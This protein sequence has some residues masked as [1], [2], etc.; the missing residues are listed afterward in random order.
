ML[1]LTVQLGTQVYHLTD[2]PSFVSGRHIVLFDPHCTFLPSISAL[3]P[4]KRIDF[5]AARPA[6][7]EQCPAQFAPYCAFGCNMRTEFGG[8]VFRFPLRT[9][10]LA[11]RSRISGQVRTL[12]WLA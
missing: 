7:M 12:R 11:A 5:V 3:N 4:G 9:P 10:A 2:V 1:A 6:L 8:T